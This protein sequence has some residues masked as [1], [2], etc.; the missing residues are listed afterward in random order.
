MLLILVAF[1]LGLFI[2]FI[3]RSLTTWPRRGIPHIAPNFPFGNFTAVFAQTQSFAHLIRALYYDVSVA[4]AR[5]TRFVGIYAG[6]RPTLLVRDPA[7]VHAVLVRD[8]AH[9]HDRGLYVDERGDPLSGNLVSLSGE[10]W[11]RLRAKLS[12]AFTAAKVRAMFGCIVSGGASLEWKL[13]EQHN[14]GQ[15]QVLEVH[16]LVAQFTTNVIASVAFG[17][18]IDCIREPELAFRAMGRKIFEAS[19]INGIRDAV[20]FLFPSLQRWLPFK[21]VDQ[22]VEDFFVSIVRQNLQHRCRERVVRADF[23]QQLVQL[24]QQPDGVGGLTE[25]ECAAQAFIFYVAGFE[26]S[27]TTMSFCLFEL[28]RNEKCQLRVRQEIER[29]IHDDGGQ[30]SLEAVQNMKY[31]DMCIKGQSARE[32]ITYSETNA[33]NAHFQKP[34][35]NTR[36]YHF[37]TAS[38]RAIG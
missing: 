37:S 35:A 27:S 21:S 25:M 33:N 7:L 1:L 12:P 11:R 36:R 24:W 22:A 6:L 3:Y 17:L 34:Y 29:A 14:G 19:V 4:P 18:D 16:E 31:L 23:F 28:A 38:A 20:G 26:T 13:N 2:A 30:L 9:F 32:Y 15:H 5:A 10:R 8:F